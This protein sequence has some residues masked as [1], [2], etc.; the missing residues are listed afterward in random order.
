MNLADM[1]LPG[2]YVTTY[3]QDFAITFGTSKPIAVT[4][5]ILTKIEITAVPSAD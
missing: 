1:Y 2:L 4:A 5:D 3:P